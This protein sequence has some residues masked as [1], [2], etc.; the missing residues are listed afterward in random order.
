[1]YGLSEAELMDFHRERVAVLVDGGADLLACDTIP[2]AI[3]A[4]A[5]VRLLDEFPG[6]YAWISYSARDGGHTNQGEAI[7]EAVHAA[8]HPQVAAVGINCTAPR[9]I[10][11]LITAMRGVTDKPILVYPNSGEEYDP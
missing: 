4:R 6:V 9:F 2:C 3:E 7:T 8:D 1:D 5:L 10:P 11:D